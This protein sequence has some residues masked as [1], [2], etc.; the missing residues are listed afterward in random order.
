MIKQTKAEG[1]ELR[2]RPARRP[3]APPRVVTHP[4]AATAN[5]G[6]FSDEAIVVGSS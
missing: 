4:I 6:L 1:S 2:D 5:N 3:Y